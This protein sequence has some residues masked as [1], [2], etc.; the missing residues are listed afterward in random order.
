MR[1]FATLLFCF[2]S[3]LTTF[4]QSINKAKLDSLFHTLSQREVAM[5]SLTISVN[6]KVQ[7]QKAIGYADVDQKIPAQITTR[8][9]VG[10]VSKMFTSVM[11]FQLVEE[12]KLKL[13][14]KLSQYFPELPNADQITI[15]H[16]LYHRSGLHNYSEGTDFKSWMDKPQTHEQMLSIIKGLKPDFE[17]DAQASYSNTNYLLLSYLIEKIGQIP[18]AQALTQR[19]TSKIGLKDTYYGG[20]TDTQKHESISYKYGEG[21]WHKEKQTD[22][23]IH[24]GAGSIIS[25][26]TDLVK[27]TE[28]LFNQK[29]INKASLN[30]MTT[31]KDG[32][33]MGIFPFEFH[34]KMAYGHNGRVEEFYSAVRYYREQKMALAYCTNGI[35]YPRVDILEGIQKIC[36]N[37]PYTIPFSKSLIVTSQDLDKY[38]GKYASDNMPIVVNVSKDN[39]RLLLETQGKV[40]EVEPIGKNYFMHAQA[41]YFFEFIPEKSELLIKETDNVYYLKKK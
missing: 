14:Q 26:P 23:S 1:L 19:I 2:L 4:S 28:A 13:D 20:A 21:T 35:L 30:Q 15:S 3:A 41:G 5:G 32:Y 9:R 22:L 17:P 36:F 25:T 29:L 40:F 38:V 39:T 37:L 34:G 12:G 27:F 33:G 8:Y 11:I 6:G 18:Y 16:L 24:S 7:Y 31:M 10:S